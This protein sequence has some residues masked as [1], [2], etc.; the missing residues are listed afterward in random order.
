MGLI[1]SESTMM[2]ICE[3]VTSDGEEA[4]RNAETVEWM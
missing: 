3:S 1:I 4:I 2:K